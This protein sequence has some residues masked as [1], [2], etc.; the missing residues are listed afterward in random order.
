[1][2]GSIEDYDAGL[3]DSER[4]ICVLLAE[5]V[6]ELLPEAES[7]VWHGHPVWFLDGNPTVGTANRSVAFG[8]CSGAARASMNRG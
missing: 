6:N 1:M 4:E 8:S 3:A 7:K 2:T 5:T